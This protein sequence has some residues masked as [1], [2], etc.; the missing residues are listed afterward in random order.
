MYANLHLHI[1]SKN[2][3]SN[4]SYEKAKII[5]FKQENI[6]IGEAEFLRA[7][8]Q[9]N[10]KKYIPSFVMFVLDKIPCGYTTLLTSEIISD[11]QNFN[12]KNTTKYKTANP[13]SVAKKLE[14]HTNDLVYSASW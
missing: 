3:F 2:P 1:G 7:L 5:A 12:E 4:T 9:K 13:K 6:W 14:N 11:V 10:E 8:L